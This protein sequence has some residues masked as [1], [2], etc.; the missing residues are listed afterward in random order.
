MRVSVSG[1]HASSADLGL[2]EMD[3][4][5]AALVDQTAAAPWLT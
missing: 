4:V 2:Q 5:T 3:R 1:G